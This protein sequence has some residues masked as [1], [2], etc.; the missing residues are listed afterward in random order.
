MS[1]VALPGVRLLEGLNWWQLLCTDKY[2]LSADDLL[3]DHVHG[4]G[5]ALNAI[6]SQVPGQPWEPSPWQE[7]GTGN[8]TLRIGNVRPLEVVSVSQTQQ[9]RPKGELLADR[10]AYPGDGIPTVVGQRPW[11]VEC[12]LWW[13]APDTVV[14]WPAFVS[15]FPALPDLS[16]VNGS[17][18][19]LWA[20]VKPEAQAADPGDASWGAV[21]TERVVEAVDTALT[22]TAI[23]IAAALAALVIVAL[24][25]RSL[26]G[27]VPSK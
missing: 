3:S 26:K 10:N 20:A 16:N 15:L 11:F 5:V 8:K 24:S 23:F 27:G 7:F 13:R 4:L 18:W 21:Q 17:E 19:V 9:P 1:A 2:G 22:G 14:P 6:F 12:R 25:V